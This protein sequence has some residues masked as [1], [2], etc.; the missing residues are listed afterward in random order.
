MFLPSFKDWVAQ[1]ILQNQSE[2][3]NALIEQGAGTMH[4]W[5]Y[6]DD[7]EVDGVP[8][9]PKVWYLLN[10]LTDIAEG[11]M[12]RSAVYVF[13]Y[14]GDFWWGRDR[15][16]DSWPVSRDGDLYEVYFIDCDG[17]PPDH[18]LEETFFEDVGWGL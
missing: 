13:E 17:E 11:L 3:V 7:A 12:L 16:V 9:V 4:F 5:Q 1:N 15:A 2:K 10:P 18:D 6:D 14:Q 8:L